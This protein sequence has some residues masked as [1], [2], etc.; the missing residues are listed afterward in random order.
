M[1]YN[2]VRGPAEAGHVSVSPHPPSLDRQYSDQQ[3]PSDEQRHT[4]QARRKCS[5]C[6]KGGYEEENH[7]SRLPTTRARVRTTAVPF[8]NIHGPH[9]YLNNN[10][11]MGYSPRTPT[12]FQLGAD[13]YCVPPTETHSQSGMTNPIGT[14]G[15]VNNEYASADYTHAATVIAHRNEDLPA[16]IPFRDLRTAAGR[17]HSPGSRGRSPTAAE[18]RTPSRRRRELYGSRTPTDTNNFPTPR[19]RDPQARPLI[20]SWTRDQSPTPARHQVPFPSIAR[21]EGPTSEVRGSTEAS[22]SSGAERM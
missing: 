8:A 13:A 17:Q 22:S 2:L 9:P 1:N 16:P 3:E 15:V 21:A 5:L 10:S 20:S 4:E 18:D 14:Q 12:S 6:E 11:V 19:F 7:R